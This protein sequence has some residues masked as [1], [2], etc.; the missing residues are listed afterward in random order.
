MKNLTRWA[1]HTAIACS[2]VLALG[3]LPAKA[4][5]QQ[6]QSAQTQGRDSHA[7]REEV[8]N[9]DRF[10][11]NHPDIE[12][13]LE[14]K[15]SL[16]N[17]AGYVRS[18]PD[19]QDY[20]NAHPRIKAELQ[21]NPDYFM[22]R[23]NRFERTRADR[24]RVR[25]QNPNP[26]LTT[27]EVSRMDQ[28]LDDHRNIEK[29]LAQKPSLINDKGYLEHHKDLARFLDEHPQVREEFAENPQYFMQRENQFEGTAADRDRTSRTNVN[30][31][32]NTA[33]ANPAPANPNPDLTT[34]QVSRMDQFLDDHPDIEKQLAKKPSLVDDKGYLDHHKDLARFLDEH[35]QVREEF[36]ENPN[37]FMRRES[38]FE[39]SAADRDAVRTDRDRDVNDAVNNKD[40]GDM[41]KFLDKHKSIAKDLDKEPSRANDQKYLD[42]HKDLRAFFDQHEHVRTEFAANPQH[43]MQ[44][45]HEFERHDDHRLENRRTD[46][47]KKENKNLDHRADTD[48]REQ[49]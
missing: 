32:P 16:V 40:L 14:T 11:D 4:R 44:R 20:L 3:V 45:E 41:H 1:H 25:A 10:L 49:R 15:P 22:R 5:W 6:D 47:D 7:T 48:H 43:F 21:E 27:Q 26:D 38:Q 2:A 37:S 46:Q 23:E 19:L 39:G 13:Q 33:P 12:Q 34:Q 29:Q 35:P 28:F 31:P 42:H 18:Q 30:P 17:D 24:D 8:S 36:A 9:F